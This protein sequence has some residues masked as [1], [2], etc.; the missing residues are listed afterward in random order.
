MLLAMYVGRMIDSRVNRSSARKTL[1]R[2]MLAS[3]A[4]TRFRISVDVMCPP[5]VSSASSTASRAFVSLW[6]ASRRRC[7]RGLS[8]RSVILAFL[9]SYS[10]LRYCITIP[11]ETLYQLD[12]R[13]SSDGVA[14]PDET[15]IHLDC[16]RSGGRCR[17]WCGGAGDAPQCCCDHY[18]GGRRGGADRRR[19]GRRVLLAAAGY[20]YTRLPVYAARRGPRFAS[21]LA[22]GGWRGLRN[23]SWSSAGE[24]GRDTLRRRLRRR[25]HF[26]SPR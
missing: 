9:D 17:R 22:A 21:R 11:G 14:F 16:T 18:T 8:A 1:A 6:P 13:S 4:L 23:I 5:P 26:A 2:P 19:S 20:R 25:R 15:G 10:A 3:R 24:R 7:A 12:T